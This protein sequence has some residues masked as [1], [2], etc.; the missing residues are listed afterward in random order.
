MD[1]IDLNSKCNSDVTNFTT[2]K[3]QPDS[4]NSEPDNPSGKPNDL[5]TRNDVASYFQID[6]GTV[7]NWT[8]KGYLG[9]LQGWQLENVTVKRL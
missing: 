7:H 3:I 8:K 5:L 4:Q 9:R 2:N 1:K 6:L